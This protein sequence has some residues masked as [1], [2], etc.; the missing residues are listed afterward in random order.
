[1][2]H[3]TEYTRF[4]TAL[5]VI[6]DPIAAVPIFLVFTKSYTTGERKRIANIA[7]LTV[8]LAQYKIGS[9]IIC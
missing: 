1:M 6:L 5:F 7:S 2:E 9:L 8:V 3:W 4:F